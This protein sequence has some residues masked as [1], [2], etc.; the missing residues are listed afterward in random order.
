[1]ALLNEI[2]IT[3][4]FEVG[5]NLIYIIQEIPNYP[6][7]VKEDNKPVFERIKKEIEEAISF[8]Y[9]IGHIENLCIALSKKYEVYHFLKDFE[10][11]EKTINKLVE[12][13]EKYDLE[14]QMKNINFLKC[15]GTYHETLKQFI[16]SKIYKKNINDKLEYKRLVEEMKVMDNLEK[17]NYQNTANFKIIE[18]FPIKFFQFPYEEKGKVYQILGIKNKKTI[19]QFDLLFSNNCIPI[20][21]IYHFPV[22][23]EGY[24]DGKY[25]DKGIENWRNIYQIRKSFFKENFCRFNIPNI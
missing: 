1:M 24:L 11:A 15:G 21:N 12:I 13:V 9:K 18:L 20:A 19:E 25:A 8:Y 3:Y 5:I 16:D 23:Q 22:I 4:E 2:K 6:I 14:K 7:P 17:N 10:K